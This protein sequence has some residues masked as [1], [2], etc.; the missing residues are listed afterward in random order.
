[1]KFFDLFD[2]LS[3][4]ED[5]INEGRMF[6]D[7]KFNKFAEN[8]GWWLYEIFEQ[9]PSDVRKMPGYNEYVSF[10]IN[11][12]KQFN[13]DFMATY[14]N[15]VYSLP[16]YYEMWLN[17][18]P[19]MNQSNKIMGQTISRFGLKDKMEG[20]DPNTLKKRGRKPKSVSVEPESQP[21]AEP[22]MEPTPE[23][24]AEPKKRGRKPIP[25]EL[26]GPKKK[27]NYYTPKGTPR[28]RPKKV[29]EPTVGEPQ[30]SEPEM[31]EPTIKEPK[32]TSSQKIQSLQDK[33]DALE[34][35]LREKGIIEEQRNKINGQLKMLK[36]YRKFL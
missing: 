12:S 30:I 14:D 3:S 1:M 18:V 5:L 9:Y 36:D 21:T 25:P 15:I 16:D 29:V 33:I 31:T 19:S 10:V 4:F 2:D 28:G 27:Y 24:T 22:E 35:L 6:T 23:L 26:R 7:E 11:K 17:T 8:A 34:K 20:R 32:M 13:Q